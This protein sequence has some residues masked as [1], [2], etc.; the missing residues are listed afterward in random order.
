M[1]KITGELW[2]VFLRKSIALKR[3]RTEFVLLKIWQKLHR[4]RCRGVCS[5]YLNIATSFIS[6]VQNVPYLPVVICLLYPTSSLIIYTNRTK[7][8]G[9]VVAVSGC[10]NFDIILR[11]S[12]P[13]RICFMTWWRHQM[14]TYSA[15]LALCVGNSPVP[16]EFPTQRAVTRSFDVFYDL[17][18]NKLFSKQSLG[19][20][21]ETLSRPFWRHCNEYSWAMPK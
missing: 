20:W 5:I 18:L 8:V 4:C 14:E 17:R 11:R 6:E 21:F 9:C 1:K 13:N 2:G 16:G 15:L 10:C 7:T 19:W 3:H 12:V